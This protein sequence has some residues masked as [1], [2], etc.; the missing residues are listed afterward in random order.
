M[1]PRSQLTD[2]AQTA[3]VSTAVG[4]VV[5]TVLLAVAFALVLSF[6]WL[7][8]PHGPSATHQEL[9]LDF[10]LPTPSAVA[11]FMPPKSV[12]AIEKLRRASPD[13]PV[14]SSALKSHRVI[15]P[16]QSYDVHL[17]FVLPESPHNRDV[18]GTFQVTCELMNGRGDVI[19]NA[20][21]PVTM[22][23]T[24]F[25]LRL[26]KL[27]FKWPLYVLDVAR[28]SQTVTLPMFTSRAELKESP[29]VAV[30]ATLSARA[31]ARQ[32]S[33]AVPHVYSA[34]ADIQLDMGPLRKFLYYYP[35]SSFV[36]MLGVTWGYLCAAALLLFAGVAAAGLV[37]SPRAFA[38][39][40]VQRAA[41]VVKGA[42][43]GGRG[44]ANGDA[45]PQPFFDGGTS[46]DDEA[47]R[48]ASG[49]SSAAES[50]SSGASDLGGA[51]TAGLRYRGAPRPDERASDA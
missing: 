48:R 49:D 22:R 13:K 6:R 31:G 12:E 2:F 10:T 15:A 4:A 3:A 16:H 38:E 23:H 14:P 32:G 26:V 39:E 34:H 40:V 9:F 30:R 29:F 25:E 41:G 28:E 50:E 35:A 36:I 1:R 21:R 18:V 37:K 5:S 27:L 47:A 43:A 33:D 44:F 20:T 51:T 7:V 45:F 8:V 17:A 24:S 11:T 42:G 19:A 46:S